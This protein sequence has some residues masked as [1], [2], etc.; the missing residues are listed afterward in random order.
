MADPLPEGTVLGDGRF[1]VGSVRGRGRQGITYDAVD[2]RWDRGVLVTELLPMGAS[3]SDGAV[4]GPAGFGAVRQRFAGDARTLARFGHPNVGR[5]IAVLD[6]N[7]TTYV[8][9]EVVDGPTLAEAIE[10]RGAFGE[11]EALDVAQQAADALAAVRLAGLTSRGLD[12][13]VLVL[14]PDGRVVLTDLGLGADRG[15]GPTPADDV[16]E[17]GGLLYH[18]LRGAPAPE[19]EE[20]LA[21]TPLVPLWRVNRQV[22]RATSHA[23]DDALALEGDARPASPATLLRRLGLGVEVLGTPD[24]VDLRDDPLAPLDR[25]RVSDPPLAPRPPF[26][27]RPVRAPEPPPAPDGPRLRPVAEAPVEDR[28]SEAAR[29][30]LADDLPPWRPPLVPAAATV[31]LVVPVVAPSGRTFPVPVPVGPTTTSRL[32]RLGVESRTALTPAER[33]ALARTV[34][35]GRRWVTVP[36]GLAAMALASAQ[37]ATLVALLVLAVAPVVATVGDRA[38]RPERAL[39]W[40][41]VWWARNLVI[42][43][44]RSVGSLMVVFLGTCLWFGAEAYGQLAPAGPWVVRGTGVLA[45]G[46]LGL[47]IGRGGEGFRSH[48]GLDAVTRWLL[49]RGRLSILGTLLMAVGLGLAA[50]G[51]AMDPRVWPL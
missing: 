2:E 24:L 31:A 29:R 12:P 39:L 51:L 5:I 48:L 30:L 11:P 7:G 17:L 50:L 41:P 19:V 10:A 44:V 16:L 13:H 1:R 38:L 36:L 49:P 37:P 45:G 40:L 42:S 6:E 32:P 23:V 14:R 25:R 35:E 18:L 4:V 27:P 20:R 47:S 26:G 34:P 9:A 8:V 33:L 22:S 43:T 3:R 15:E 46:L 21:G 28:L